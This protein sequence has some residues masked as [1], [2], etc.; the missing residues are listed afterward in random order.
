MPRLPFL[1]LCI[2]ATQIAVA[3]P[4]YAQTPVIT[5]DPMKDYVKVVLDFKNEP[6]LLRGYLREGQSNIDLYIIKSHDSDTT[7]RTASVRWIDGTLKKPV[8]D[9]INSDFNCSSIRY[10][11]RCRK[12][13]SMSI[14][15]T[16]KS[17]RSLEKWA[18]ENRDGAIDF[19]LQSNYSDV[20][21]EFK[22]KADQITRFAEALREARN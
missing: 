14:D 22:L 6:F 20:N 10:G 13:Q 2:V 3:S 7:F 9:Q 1:A 8:L 19:Q 18:E 15:I 11:G 16:E 17:W 5:R 21:F 12:T 4:S